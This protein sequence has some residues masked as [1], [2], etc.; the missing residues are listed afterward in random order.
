MRK[1]Y[2]FAVLMAFVLTSFAQF[3]KSVPGS[4]SFSAVKVV[5]EINNIPNNSKA[6]V[7]SLHYDGP[8]NN[9]IGTNSADT[10]TVFAFFDA[11]R[12]AAHHAAGNHITSVKLYINGV[13][14]VA[15]AGLRFYSNQTTMVY[16][17]PFTPVEGWNN[18]VLTTPLA[19]PATD[20]YVGYNI[21]VTGGYPGGCDTA[22][23]TNPNGN[24]IIYRGAWQHLTDLS[25]ALTY[26]WNIRAMVDGTPLVNPVAACSPLTWAAGT[27][28]TGSSTTSA[29]FTLTNTGGGTMTVSSI[30]GLSAPFTTSLVPAS[31][32][33]AAHQSVT[34][35]FTYAP[36]AVTTT[37][38]TAVINTNGG[39]I[40]ITLSGTGRAP[41]GVMNG[42]FENVEDFALA[43]N[44]WTQIDIDTTATYGI[45]GVTFPHSGYKGSFIAFN[46]SLCTPALSGAYDAHSGTKYGA[47]IAALT[48]GAPNNDWLIT[49]QKHLNSNSSVSLWVK[50]L[51][52]D[53]GFEKYEVFVSTTTPTAGA[54]TSLS[55]GVQSADTVWTQKTYDLNSYNGQNIYIGIHCTSNDAFIFMIDDINISTTVGVDDM[56]SDL[57]QVYPNPVKGFLNIE[58]SR[59]IESLEIFNA[60][61]QNVYSAIVNT[62][63]VSVNFVD[64]NTGVYF[65]KLK[66]ASGYTVRKVVV[67]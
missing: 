28:A 53:Y 4:S 1:I 43:F 48:A 51:T 63:L 19:I 65:L 58:S 46:P 66:T 13:T 37:N 47:C 27:I 62:P 35:T 6:I 5:K 15:S 31:V 29:N 50:S 30:S 45:Q 33:L 64:M 11:A 36:T 54:M 7:D 22:S 60:I 67:E 32:S 56:G 9:S 20:L 26:H 24:W 16:S 38:Q 55:G 59:A 41:Y 12:L 18:V 2:L 25:A 21:I 14:N 17:Q 3:S 61:G 34:F 57:I 39:N 40:S 42:D 10:F 49:P 8:N 44:G 23:V 52:A